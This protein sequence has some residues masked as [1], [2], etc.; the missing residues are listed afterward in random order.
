M[1]HFAD[2]ATVF[3]GCCARFPFEEAVKVGGIGETEVECYF[4]GSIT[5]MD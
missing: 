4:P 1:V 5:G 3:C 2:G